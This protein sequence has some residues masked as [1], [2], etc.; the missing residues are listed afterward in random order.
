MLFLFD[1]VVAAYLA[2]QDIN[3]LNSACVA[4]WKYHSPSQ[5]KASS[6]IIWDCLF[7]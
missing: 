6:G 2:K 4:S 1:I 3:S 7:I 5:S